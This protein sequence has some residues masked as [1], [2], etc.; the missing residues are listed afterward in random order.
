MITK[1]PLLILLAG[2]AV[3]L[4]SACTTV[5]TQLQG[6]YAD[7]SPARV[8]ADVFGSAVRWGGVIIETETE[9]QQTCFEILSRPLSKYFRPLEVDRTSGRF[10]A[11]KS[12]FHDPQIYAAG[13]E[14]TL[15]GR[16][17]S[18]EERKIDEF[19]YRYPVVMVDDM[20]MWEVRRD[21]RYYHYY[22]PFYSPFYRGYPYYWG[23]YPYYHHPRVGMGVS[24]GYSST[25]R[26]T[27]EPSVVVPHRKQ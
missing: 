19:N 10:I 14:V 11:C 23:Y 12:G 3:T 1:N 8:Q 24:I 22:D 5:P 15:T 4:L 7:I 21:V 13:R 9:R 16:I 26:S 20:V 18:I 27:P 2:L 25:R 6:E 17:E